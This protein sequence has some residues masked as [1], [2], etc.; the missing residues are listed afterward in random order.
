M[1]TLARIGASYLVLTVLLMACATPAQ[2]GDAQGAGSE[3][4]RSTAPK[5]ILAAIRGD[6]FTL[7]DAINSAGGGRVAGVREIEQLLNSG[8]GVVDNQGQVRPLLAEAVPSLQN[9]LWKLLPDGR[10][11]TTWKLRPNAAWHDGAPFTSADVQ[12]AA[13]IAVNPALTI[14]Q[15]AAYEFLERI[16][17]PDPQTV[18]VTWK[19]VFIEADLLFTRAADRSRILPMPRHLLDQSYVDDPANILQHPYWAYDFVGTGPYRLREWTNG[20]HMVLQANDAFVLGRP[21]VDEVQIKFLW[22]TNVVLANVLSGAVELTLGSGLSLD[23]AL[24]VR[25]QWRDGRVE[26]PLE[27]IT[28]LWPQFIN[29]DPPV[30]ADVRFRRA[31][32]HALD[33]QQIID[34]FLGG[35]VPVAHSFVGPEEP[36]YST[37]AP[38]VVR[39]DYDPRR[40]AQ[41]VE[42]TGYTKGPDGMY[43]DATGRRLVV[44]VRTTAHPLREQLQ[45]VLGDYWQQIGVGLDAVIIPRQ[46][47]ADREYRATTLGFDFRFNP[48]EFTR[49]HSAQ[50][51]LPENNYRGN[52]SARYRSPELDALID[53]YRVTIPRPERVEILAQAMRH[54]T[55]QL[56]VVPLFHDAEPVLI[57]NRLV[58][59]GSRKGDALQPWN[60]HEW[61]VK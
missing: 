26:T 44:E 56:V 30:V 6:P 20:S 1:V 15:D 2:R 31:L 8:L 18:V 54:M 14:A 3:S 9:G 27:T 37:V 7:V 49:Y 51:P 46:R 39:Y 4:Q 52:N 50:V 16:E 42:E 11:E 24:L 58:N 21:K 33:R 57:H 60:A 28:A 32:V 36:D 25:E 10:M 48:P 47:A 61:D 5:R 23:Q 22:D 53:R 41:L 13:M 43:R 12:F 59:V 17:T 29:P 35:L 38:S 19:G 34:T 40:A 45:P 55:D